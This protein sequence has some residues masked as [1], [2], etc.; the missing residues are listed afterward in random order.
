M[1]LFDRAQKKAF[2][3]G[4]KK[5]GLPRLP[6]VNSS[7]SLREWGYQASKSEVTKGYQREIIEESSS[8]IFINDYIMLAKSGLKDVEVEPLREAFFLFALN[9][10]RDCP[11]DGFM[12]M[13]HTYCKHWRRRLDPAAWAIIEEEMKVRLRK[14]KEQKGN[15]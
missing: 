3:H 4:V 1:S 5:Q 2:S 15:G 14:L 13:G 8:D 6:E 7:E 12:A 11:D 10:V 9:L